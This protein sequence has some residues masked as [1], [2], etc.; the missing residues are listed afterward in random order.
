M[1]PPRAARFLPSQERRGC[2]PSKALSPAALWA[3]TSPSCHLH[4]HLP[5]SRGK[6]ANTLVAPPRAARFLPPRDGAAPRPRRPH[7]PPSGTSP[8]CHLH[9]HL[10][11]SREKG[12]NT[13]VAP[14]RAARFLPRS[15][16]SPC[17]D[18]CV[19]PSHTPDPADS[20]H[21]SLPPSRGKGANT[22][23]APPRAARFLPPRALKRGNDGTAAP[24]AAHSTLSPC[25]DICIT[26]SHTPDPADSPPS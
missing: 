19:T 24:R 8:S 20:P 3:V 26:P 5:P 7:P 21:P 17:R 15:T 1:A 13:L 23:V 16:L 10:P 2:A 4:P 22:L 9:P 11:P 12:A 25:R 6:G 14:P 18:L